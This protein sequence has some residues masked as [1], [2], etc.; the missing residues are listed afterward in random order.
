VADGCIQILKSSVC[1][2]QLVFAR[3][4]EKDSEAS[5]G[6][7]G[8]GRDWGREGGREGEGEGVRAVVA[9]EDGGGEAKEGGGGGTQDG[10]REGGR[11][12]GVICWG[13][14]AT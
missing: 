7:L 14:G 13:V 10:G 11:E 9:V 2:L 6:R 1:V 12:G 8:G 5:N 3:Q 4:G